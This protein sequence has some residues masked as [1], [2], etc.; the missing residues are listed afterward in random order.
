MSGLSEHPLSITTNYSASS[1]PI[2]KQLQPNRKE[3][4]ED[5][6][7]GDKSWIPYDNNARHAVWLPC[8]AETP[9][10]PK[11]GLHSRQHLFPAWW[12]AKGPIS[13]ELLPPGRTLT[14]SIYI[15]QLQKLA[16]ALREKRPRRANVHL[17]HD[18]ARPH[19]ASDT[20]QEIAELEW[21]PVV[22]KDIATSDHHLFQPLKLYL[23]GEKFDKCDD[24]KMAVDE[25]VA[26]QPPEFWRKGINDLPARWAKVIDMSGDCTP[27]ISYCH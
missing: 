18:S 14:T 19:I 17:L 4:L 23:Q 2:Q 12:D 6:V 20:R 10:Q 25:F 9:M 27:S 5:L 11:P 13:Y 21:H 26:S 8:D 24:L 22:L 16:D 3:F 1:R 7:I 15:V